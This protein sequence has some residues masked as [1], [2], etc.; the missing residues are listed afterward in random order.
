MS[1]KYLSLPLYYQQAAKS[2]IFPQVTI[3]RFVNTIKNTMLKKSIAQ[4]L[5]IA[6]DTFYR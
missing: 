4:R 3:D 2:S 6:K 1:Y 5:D